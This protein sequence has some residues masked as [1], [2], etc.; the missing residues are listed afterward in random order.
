MQI[1]R[2]LPPV[3]FWLG[4]CELCKQNAYSHSVYR[5]FLTEPRLIQER[6]FYE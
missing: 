2:V 6:E 3:V 5:E 4:L 1:R